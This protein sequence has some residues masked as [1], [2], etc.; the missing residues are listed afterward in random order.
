MITTPSL[1]LILTLI[2]LGGCA[3]LAGQAV[4][5]GWRPAWQAALYGLLLGLGDRFLIFAL[6]GGELTSAVGFCLDA[7]VLTVVCLASWRAA[8]ARRMA[9]QYP[10]LYRR[11]GLFGGRPLLADDRNPTI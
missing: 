11:A 7:G 1:F 6:F 2:L 10:W 4:G 9:L 5:N 3:F 8:R